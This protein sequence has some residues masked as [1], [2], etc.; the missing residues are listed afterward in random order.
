M[1]YSINKAFPL[2]IKEQ[3]IRQLR[4]MMDQGS[5][6]PGEMLM[7]AKD[8]GTFLDINRNTVAAVYKELEAQGRLKVI[9]GSGTFVQKTLDHPKTSQVWKI[10]DQAY[11][12]ACQTG[13]PREA[14]LDT[15]ITGL[16]KKSMGSGKERRVILVDCNFE[17]LETLDKRIQEKTISRFP[18]TTRPLLIQ[19]IEK[20]PSA[21][22][23]QAKKVD[24]VICGM[25][26]LEELMT[27]VPN[28][29]VEILGFFI[30]TDFK[31]MN[32]IMQLP[33][34]TRTGY[35]CI[36][37]KSATAFFKKAAFSS[38]SRLERRHVGIDDKKAVQDMLETC[39]PVFATHYVYEQLLAG[40]PSNTNIIRVD[41]DIDLES[42][43]FIISRLEKGTNK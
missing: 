29:P 1:I 14:I 39:N 22:L 23:E 4:A 7:S 26:H 30:R 34:G 41:L 33:P 37:N 36:S 32:Q 43:D 19:E 18:V 3:I 31:I 35:C 9:K 17:V 11:E 20:N 12:K 16:L 40:A 10:F 24:L 28:T 5:L 38:G 21:F 15:F 6:K 27:A 42:L 8:M 13:L 25:N 2:G